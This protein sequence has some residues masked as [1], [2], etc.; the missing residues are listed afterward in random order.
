MQ[1]TP[2]KNFLPGREEGCVLA[3]LYLINAEVAIKGVW[4]KWKFYMQRNNLI[5]LYLFVSLI[6][7]KNVK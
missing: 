1:K 4:N 2:K 3:N 5:Y 6:K 7:E